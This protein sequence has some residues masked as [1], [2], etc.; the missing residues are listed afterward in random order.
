MQQQQ[1]QYMQQLQNKIQSI[2][3]QLDKFQN[4]GIEVGQ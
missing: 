2:T 1:Q 3:Q 4:M